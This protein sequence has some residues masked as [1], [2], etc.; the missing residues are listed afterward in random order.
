L[1][2]PLN[3]ILGF[4]EILQ[5]E[6]FGP[7]G[8]P[9]Y[10]EYAGSIHDSGAHLLGVINDILDL[11]RLDSGTLELHLEPVVLD[12]VVAGCIAAIMPLAA[13]EN[14]ALQ[15]Q[16]GPVTILADARRL[17]QM[18]FNLLSNA[19]KFTPKGGDVGVSASNTPDGFAITVRDTGIGMAHDDIPKALERFGQ[20]DSR[21]SRRYEGT[22]LGLPLTKEFA[23]LQGATLSIKSESGVGTSVTILFPVSAVLPQSAQAKAG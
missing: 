8:N 1:R 6:T 9:R 2:T 16:I 7:V 20:I 10:R 18:L 4:S 17:R 11:S 22:G 12:D 13:R 3:A 14:I 5:N 21:L 15:R 23:E 19:V